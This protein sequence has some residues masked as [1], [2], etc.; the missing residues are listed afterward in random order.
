MK[1]ED[2]KSAAAIGRDIAPQ[3]S[4]PLIF[5]NQELLTTNDTNQTWDQKK[6]INK[7]NY[8]NFND[9]HVSLLFQH[10]NT[11]EQILIEAS[12]EPCVN[13]ELTC[14]LDSSTVINRTNY[15]LCYILIDDG[16]TIA[17]APVQLITS[18]DNTLKVILP[19]KSPITT[20]RKSRRYNCHNVTCEISQDDFRAKG[21]LINFAPSGLEIKLSGTDNSKQ[22]DSKKSALITLTQNG[23]KLFSGLCRCIRN[24][25]DS[26]K[27]AVVYAPLD[28]KKPLFVKREMRNPRQHIN[29]AF[30]ASFRHP[31]FQ[32]NVER[33]I[34]EISTSGFSLRD[35]I[36]EETLLPGMI[37][38]RL[39]IVYAGI[40]KM[41]CSAQVIYREED[42]ENK[43]VKCGLAITDMNV[44]S[45]SHLN[46][47]LG[48]YLDGYAR[49]STEVD[50][51]ALWEFFFDTG[52]I[53][54][55]KYQHLQHY[56]NTFKETYRKL[57]QESPEIAS[58]FVYEENGKIYGHMS[59]V[60]AYEHSWLIHHFAAR[61]MES[62]I[63]G[64]MIL[65]QI[66]HYLNG[67][68]RF[69][70]GGMN[71]IA[72]YYRPENEIMKQIFGGIVEYLG[73]R[74]G[75]SL[76]LFSYM[77][78]HKTSFN[79]ELPKEWHLRECCPDDF[80]KLKNFYDGHFGGLMLDAF[81]LES[82]I[83][84]LRESFAKAGFKRNCQT[85]CLCLK[86]KQA[87]FFI[88]NKSDLGLNLSDLLNC[89]AI[90]IISD[91]ELKW[92]IISATINKLSFYYKEGHIPLL[93]YPSNYLSGQG[94]NTDK[95]YELWILKTDPF[96]EQYTYYMGRK[97][98]TRYRTTNG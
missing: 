21:E 41:D 31:L 88:V 66:T 83:T 76:D 45:Y 98:R 46:H 78:F 81:G 85:F 95:N 43:M 47:I 53:Y 17:S 59:M 55:E 52:F 39:T 27:G 86:G 6:L 44:Q 84:P 26:P 36:E 57:Y 65:R 2:G 11:G 5:K 64:R 82:P 8:I 9:G 32:G 13:N 3:Y 49:V 91:E 97:F 7:L 89:I 42:K 48:V 50:L 77:L 30:R 68:Y 75:S 94:I 71:Y 92:D 14:R 24:D 10:K 40:V 33:D 80:I 35:S 29:P 15:D 22:L 61:Q 25:S 60:H 38:P 12:P 4:Q 69:A 16:I 56:R 62:K 72:A 54:G 1:E 73:N 18:D 87:A 70:S 34:L 67:I 74:Q 96:L 28:T 90:I 63:A 19:E 58:H 79:N 37:I 20:K 51:D 23:V 93:I